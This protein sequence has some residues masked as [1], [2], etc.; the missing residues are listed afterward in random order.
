[1]IAAFGA[2]AMVFQ[3]AALS[4]LTVFDTVGVKLG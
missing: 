3:A 2:E 1:M 4:G